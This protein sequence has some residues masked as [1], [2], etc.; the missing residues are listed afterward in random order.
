MFNA[1]VHNEKCMPAPS[2]TQQY[3]WILNM[4]K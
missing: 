4:G 3:M 1:R 2:F